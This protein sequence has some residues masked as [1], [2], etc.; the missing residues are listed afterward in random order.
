MVLLTSVF[1]FFYLRILHGRIISIGK[2]S[3]SRISFVIVFLLTDCLGVVGRAS[4]ANIATPALHYMRSAG[5]SVT[6]CLFYF[7]VFFLIC[8]PSPNMCFRPIR[9]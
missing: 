3:A 8:K 1:I 5:D 7:F 4:Y 6:V 9:Q 2:S